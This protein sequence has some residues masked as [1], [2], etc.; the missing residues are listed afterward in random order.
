MPLNE[1][2]PHGNGRKC[3]FV[4]GKQEFQFPGEA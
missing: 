4:A 1:Q 3:G 2:A